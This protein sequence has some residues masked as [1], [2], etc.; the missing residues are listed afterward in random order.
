VISK[1]KAAGVTSV[2]FSGDPVA[3]ANFTKEATAQEYFPEWILGPQLLVDTTAYART[4]DQRQ[5]AHAFGPSPLTA[6]IR[7]ERAAAY[8]LYQW[9]QGT[10]PPAPDTAQVILPNPST[11]FAALQLAGPKL[12]PETFRDG[13]FSRAPTENAISQ[14]SLSYGDHGF[15]PYED[16]NGVDDMTEVWWDPEAKGPDE[17]RKEGTGMWRYVDG[18]KRYYPGEW[19]KDVKLFDKANTV[20]IFDEPPKGEAAPDFPKP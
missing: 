1:F 20:T 18:G 9:F 12:T 5:W 7:P 11:L 13:L 3:P 2:V 16:W 4:Y 19:T 10:A 15:W 17:I 14:S 8:Q 6:R